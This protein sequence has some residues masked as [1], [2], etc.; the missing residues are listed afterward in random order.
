MLPCLRLR[1]RSTCS[2]IYYKP[3]VTIRPFVA[4]QQ[5]LAGP[6]IKGCLH[7]ESISMR[8]LRKRLQ[9]GA[10]SLCETNNVLNIQDMRSNSTSIASYVKKTLLHRL[11][12]NEEWRLQQ[13]TIPASDDTTPRPLLTCYQ[14]SKSLSPVSRQT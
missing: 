5:R 3:N 4:P 13:S 14:T 7:L 11:L 2:T 1:V 6:T 9:R 8:T 10:V 12:T